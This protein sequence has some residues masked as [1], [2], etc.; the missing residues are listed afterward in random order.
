[1]RAFR[2]AYDGRPFHGYQRQP[3]VRT[4]EGDL[5]SALRS[6]DVCAPDRAPPGYAAAGRTDAGVS[7]LAQT[8]ALDAPEW[9][10]PRALNSE[11]PG[12]IRAYAA[13]DAPDGFHPTHHAYRREYSYYLY[14]PTGEKQS[15]ASLPPIDDE[16]AAAAL[17]H[18]CGTH[19]F[20]NLTPDAEGTHRG[21]SGR[22]DRDGGFLRIKFAAGGFARELVR[23][24]VTVIHRAGIDT[25]SIDAVDRLLGPESIDGGDGIAPAPPEPLVL[26][27]VVYPQLSFV[28]DEAARER[29][30]EAI[31]GRAIEGAIVERTNASIVEG[32]REA[33]DAASSDES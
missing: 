16:R 7:A 21:L 12:S 11:L 8:I 31:G 17:E 6:L 26:S 33:G 20:H 5:F 4:V 27:A 14:A 1:M 30:I 22:L 29:A 19:D 15:I 23:R 13:A 10:S 32:L 9:L 25:L 24:L 28:V 18:L 2:L 3:D